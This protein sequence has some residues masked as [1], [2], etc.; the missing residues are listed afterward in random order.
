MQVQVGHL[1]EEVRGRRTGCYRDMHGLS[2]LLGFIRVAEQGVHR[3]CGVKMADV[4]V[5]Q[6]LPD[7]RVVD[8]PQTVVGST[9]RRHSPRERPA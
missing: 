4:L 2:E 3:G 9:D 6:Q 8:L 7:Q 5:F 1:L